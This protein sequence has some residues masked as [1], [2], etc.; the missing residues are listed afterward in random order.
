MS[1]SDYDTL[2]VFQSDPIDGTSMPAVS[3]QCPLC[4][5]FIQVDSALGGQQVACPHCQGV[6]GL[7]PESVLLEMFAQSGLPAASGQEGYAAAGEMPG[8]LVQLACP[9]C[10]GPFQL[11]AAMGGQQ[12]G[13]PHCGS[14]MLAPHFQ[15]SGAFPDYQHPLPGMPGQGHEQPATPAS[16]QA[17]EKPP[18]IDDLLPPGLSMSP[19]AAATTA[20]PKAPRDDRNPPARQTPRPEGRARL[21]V[22]D[23]LPPTRKHPHE[24]VDSSSDRLPPPK[25]RSKPAVDEQMPPSARKAPAEDGPRPTP[26]KHIDD[27]LPPGAV[28]GNQPPSDQAAAAEQPR[29]PTLLDSL[30]PPGAAPS[31]SGAAAP[32]EQLALPKAPKRPLVAPGNLPTGAIAVPTPEGGFVTIKET[33][34]TIGQGSDVIEVRRLTPEE[35]ARRRLWKNIIFGAVCLV[36][37]LIV[38]VVM[39]RQ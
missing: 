7:P 10:A 36:V 20:P 12:V 14:V 35:K 17:A 21:P 38:I 26:R 18:P 15:P 16:D 37:L 30:L 33:P 27:L 31:E 5:G 8:E 28:P 25:A 13:C 22:D 19:P 1:A 39:M 9:T 34:K 29:Q 11:S 24:P 4:T 2:F 6:M 23:R 32:G 3:L